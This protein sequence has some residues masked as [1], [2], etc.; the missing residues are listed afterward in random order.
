[1]GVTVFVTTHYMQEA[2]YC[3]RV[4]L[5]YRGRLIALGTPAELKAQSISGQ[6]VDV[7]CDRPQAA[8]KVVASLPEVREASLFGAGLHVA[9]ADDEAAAPAIERALRAEGIAAE[10]IET[11]PPGMEDVF[12]A[13]IEAHDRESGQEAAHD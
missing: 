6:I 5:I 8:R 13:L 3:D 7:R 12:V 9:T 10:R 2:E 11:V 1:G 4:A